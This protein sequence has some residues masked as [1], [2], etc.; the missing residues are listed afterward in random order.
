[1]TKPAPALGTVQWVDLTV[2]DAGR[3]RDFS[4]PVVGWTP[5][6]VDMGS[7]EDFN[8]VAPSTGKPAGRHLP[9]PRR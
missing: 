2:P 5:A 7:H 9:R 4:Q 6:P 1:M 8:M 3:V